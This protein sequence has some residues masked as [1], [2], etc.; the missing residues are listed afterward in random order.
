MKSLEDISDFGANAAEADSLLAKC[1]ELHPVTQKAVKDRHFLI[2]GRK[3]SGKTA[4][5]KKI[6]SLQDI[7]EDVFAIECDLTHYPWGYHN[8]MVVLSVTEQER[9]LHSWRYFILLSLAKILLNFD[10][11]QH[12]TDALKKIKQFVMDTYGSTDPD[13]TK[14]FQP[15]KRL[16]GLKSLG[17]EIPGLRVEGEADEYDMKNLPIMFQDVNDSLQRLIIESLN[18]SHRYYVCFDG[19]DFD[20]QP[21]SVDYKHRLMGLI[22]AAH[23]LNNAASKSKLFLKILIFLR[24]DIYKNHLR[25]DD[26]NKITRT[27]G[28]EIEWDKP[29]QSVTLKSMMERRFAQVLEIDREGAWEQVFDESVRMGAYPTKYAYILDHTCRRPRDIIEFCN[30]ILNVYKF[31]RE[32]TEASLPEK[33]SS[34]D[35]FKARDEYGQYFYDELVDEIHKQCPDYEVYFDILRHVGYQQFSKAAFLE[36]YGLLKE[37]LNFPKQPEQ[38]LEDLFEFSVIGFTEDL[39][40]GLSKAD[41]VFRYINGR[42]RFNRSIEHFSVHLGLVTILDLKR[43]E[44]KSGF[45]SQDPRIDGSISVTV[46][47]A[48]NVPSHIISATEPGIIVIDWFVR[49]SVVPALEGHWMVQVVME[50]LGPGPEGQI[51]QVNVPVDSGAYSASPYPSFSYK[52]RLRL[53]DNISPGVYRL[54]TVVS[55]VLPDGTPGQVIGYEEGPILQIYAG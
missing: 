53:P 15:G 10:H 9:Y 41:Y 31:R 12:N 5:C 54:A 28:L 18:P 22:L 6:L 51:D 4:I 39:T 33:F 8:L 49:G 30:C 13:I 3:G 19:L 2:L 7:R 47:N 44:Y 29:H 24:S 52:H 42:I 16:R 34:D 26:K 25:S 32:E 38:I 17:I 36:A 23:G 55:L 14:L 48:N 40:R 20:F 1:F 37:H 50:S 11:S 45:Q 43:D 46:L 21:D 35:I 27:Y